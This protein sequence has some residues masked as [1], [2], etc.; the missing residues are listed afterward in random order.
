MGTR[1][2]I[3]IVVIIATLAAVSVAAVAQNQGQTQQNQAQ[4]P[5]TQQNQTQPTQTQPT[6]T[7]QAQPQPQQQK[8]KSFWQ[9]VQ[10][11]AQQGQNGQ[12]TVQNTVQNGQS[13]VQQGTGAVQG[14]TQGVQGAAQSMPGMQQAV[15]GG[16]AGATSISG[17]GGG[18]SCGSSC[19]DAGPFQA[20]V[21]QMTMSQQGAYHII[22]MNI[23]FRNS[24]NQPLIIAYHDGSMAMVD[25]NGATYQGAG[26][27]PGELQGMGI[28]RGNQTD[29]QFQLAPGQTGN[30]MFS[31]ARWRDNSSPIGT[32]FSY[33]LTIDEL[34]A[35]NGAMAIPVRSYSL[36]FPSL[37]PSTTSAS[38]PAPGKGAAVGSTGNSYAGAAAP[39]TPATH[40]TPK[41][42]TAVTP[43]QQK[44]AVQA[45][46]KSSTVNNAAMTSTAAKPAAA[47]VKPIPTT[48]TTTKKPTT[49]TT[50]TTTN[51]T[52]TTTPK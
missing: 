46:V 52:N 31:V 47:A 21:S 32:G 16:T 26:G 41:A 45:V 50:T 11:M 43:A 8:K 3:R 19:F 13:T 37:S 15:A 30:A 20:N 23:Q 34:Q 22:R 29:S 7:Q 2:S 25:N 33:N 48:T 14:A 18:A 36:N 17:N 9:K 49:T 44:A 39:A 27:S 40:V 12:N 5:Q 51:Q 28:D 1:S 24:T 4:Q 38:F 6:Q 42:S 10:D 35:Q